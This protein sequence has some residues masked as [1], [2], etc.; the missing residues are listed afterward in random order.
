MTATLLTGGDPDEQY[1]AP[2]NDRFLVDDWWDTPHG[3]DKEPP[4]HD[5]IAAA[6]VERI[7]AALIARHDATFKHLGE[8]AVAYRWKR[9]GGDAG[10]K[11]TLGK[12]VKTAG[13]V[14]HFGGVDF[15][16]W[17][18]AD[19]CRSLRLTRWQV[20]ALVYH[21]LL[22]TERDEK[23]KPIVIPHDFAGFAKEIEHYG[24]WQP[25]LVLA[26]CAIQHLQLPL[27]M[28]GEEGRRAAD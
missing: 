8:L 12:C 23:G 20:E 16:I 14:K 19:H 24:L 3:D 28:P 11:A 25:D 21:E 18:A 10:G 1:P 13:L 9:E 26:G 2:S 6:D 27:F 22:H 7:A 5:F 4:R 15:V 17:L